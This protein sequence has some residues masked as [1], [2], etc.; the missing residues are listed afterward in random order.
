MWEMASHVPK[1]N[2]AVV[3]RIQYKGDVLSFLGKYQIVC[4]STRD[5]SCS[6]RLDAF[7]K[8]ETR[9]Q[10]TIIL[11]SEVRGL[12]KYDGTR[13]ETRFRLSVKRTSP[14]K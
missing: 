5:F 10:L 1:T 14:F 3:S 6:V 7:V 4:L 2:C 8:L 12:L 11:A 13:T 9:G